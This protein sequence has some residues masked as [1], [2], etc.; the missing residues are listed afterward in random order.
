[1][2][3][4]KRVAVLT[5]FVDLLEAFSLCRV[6]EGQL[7]SLLAGGYFTTFV[8]CEG[9]RPQGVFANPLLRQWRLPVYSV[10]RDGDAVER[11]AAFRAAVDA[12]K[13]KLAPLLEEVDVVITHDIVFLH[14]Y[15]V[16]N[17][18]CRELAKENPR[19]RWLHWIHSAPAAPA[20]FSNGDPR[21]ARFTP[22]PRSLLVYPNAYDVPRVAEQFRVPEDEIRIVPHALDYNELFDF[23][24]L[25]RALIDRYDLYAPTILAVY[26]LRMDRGKQPDKLIRLFSELK[27][28]GQSVRLIIAAFHSTGEHFL[29]YRDELREEIDR[30]GLSEDEV[31]FTNGLESLPGVPDEELR[32]YQV[33]LPHKVVLDLF[34]LS[35]IYVHPSASET[36][37]LVCQEAAA[38]GNLLFL[39]ADF[40]PMREVY[41]PSAAYVKFSSS[42]FTTTYR[43]NELAY[44]AEVAQ[45]IVHALLYE[46]TVQQKTRLR[47][48]RNLDAVFKNHLEP[49]LY[50]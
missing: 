23:H 14:H 27:R 41:G 19:V 7:K 12:V 39:N 4:L 1:M 16:Y 18:A 6:V 26:P 45:K 44:Y 31:V 32:R 33:E 10:E 13:R 47:Q 25:T 48:T 43:P 8:A 29:D 9:F 5:T 34:H 21:S 46:K 30:L 50:V 28:A 40:P 20:A 17:V 24:P 42:L 22:F 11:P 3:A 37:S 49:L 35:N 38:C 15:L 2:P 36:Y